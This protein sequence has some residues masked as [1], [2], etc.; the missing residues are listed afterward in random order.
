MKSKEERKEQDKKKE[1]VSLHPPSPKQLRRHHISHRLFQ[2]Q[3]GGSAV[4]RAFASSCIEDV[5][6]SL[7]LRKLLLMHDPENE[8]HKH[9]S[10]NLKRVSRI[11][12][13]LAVDDI[14]V[15][16]E[17]S[18]LCVAFDISKLIFLLFDLK[19]CRDLF[20]LFPQ[21]FSTLQGVGSN[22]VT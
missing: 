4:A 14:L 2:R 13:I 22:S 8:K 1:I 15:V 16:L 17:N 3:L 20:F 12:E 21:S 5:F 11:S 6:Q 19:A 7:T 10:P 18:G 9:L